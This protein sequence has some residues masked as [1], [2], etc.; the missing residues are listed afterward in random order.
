MRK[1][2][3]ALRW[4][5]YEQVEPVAVYL[6]RKAVDIVE[7]IQEAERQRVSAYRKW[8]VAERERVFPPATGDERNEWL[9]ANPEFPP[10]D[11]HY[12]WQFY[13]VDLVE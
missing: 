1:C 11:E 2:W 9:M 12:D 7:K 8:W 4:L 5:D 3:V 6:S 13:E 10:V